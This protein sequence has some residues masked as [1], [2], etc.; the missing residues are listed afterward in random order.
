MLKIYVA[1]LSKFLRKLLGN[2][3]N[4]RILVKPLER[5]QTLE[6]MIGKTSQ[7]YSFIYSLTLLNIDVV[8]V[9]NY[10]LFRVH[11]KRLR[12]TSLQIE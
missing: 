9:V 1:K 3:L 2:A 5:G 6:A 7:I 4:Y 10:Y 11:N 12:P 8:D